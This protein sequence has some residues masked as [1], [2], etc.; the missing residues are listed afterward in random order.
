[1]SSNVI[2]YAGYA[3]GRRYNTGLCMPSL[4]VQ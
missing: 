4:S 3:D 1:M 2:V